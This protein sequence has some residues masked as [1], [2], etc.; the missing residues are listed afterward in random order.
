MADSSTLPKAARLAEILRRF[1]SRPAA[2][3][4]G[5]ASE[6]LARCVNEVEDELAGIPCNPNPDPTDDDGWISQT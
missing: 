6:Q 1:Q 4:H 2:A 3:S 5:E